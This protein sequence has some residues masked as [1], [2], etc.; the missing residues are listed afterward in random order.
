M[1]VL[2]ADDEDDVRDLLAEMIRR[3]PDLELVAATADAAEAIEAAERE[4]PDVAIIDAHMPEGGGVRAL[5]ELAA[6][7]PGTATVVLSA[8]DSQSK[9]VEHLDAGAIA[10]LVKPVSRKDLVA[11]L[12]RAVAAHGQ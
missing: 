7:V 8:F 12:E 6:R 3:E 11:T 1:R 9:V 2:I 5:K 4:R 10:Y